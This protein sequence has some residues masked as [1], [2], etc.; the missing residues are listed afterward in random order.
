MNGKRYV[1]KNKV[2][3]FSFIFLTSLII[4]MMVY[5]VSVSGHKEP[6]YET[7]TINSGDT[8]WS[9]AQQYNSDNR[10]IRGY[11]HDIKK[12][13]NLDSSLL[14]ENTSIIIPVEN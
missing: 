6:C 7:V 5:T 9:I 10:D 14:I 11:I 1:L 3:F 4:F 8:L 2:K 12:L 13:N